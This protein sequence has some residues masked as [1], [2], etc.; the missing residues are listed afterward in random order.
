MPELK[1]EMP[2]ITSLDIVAWAY[3]KEEMVNT[4]ESQEVKDLKEK[5]P[6]LVKFVSF[7][8]TIFKD[9][10]SLAKPFEKKL[11]WNHSPDN[12]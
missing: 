10:E 8:D 9:I 2:Q 4:P 1:Q 11:V 5:Y 7:M 6:N 3:L 12:A